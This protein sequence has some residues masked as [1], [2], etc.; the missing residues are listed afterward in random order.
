MRKPL[1]V[2]SSRRKE[3][4]TVFAAP[5]TERKPVTTTAT[6]NA[7]TRGKRILYFRLMGFGIFE[8]PP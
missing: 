5:S 8:D 2:R 6:K 3:A 7:T 4:S 1:A